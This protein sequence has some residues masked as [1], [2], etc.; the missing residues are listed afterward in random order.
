MVVQINY[1]VTRTRVINAP[2]PS[3]FNLTQLPIVVSTGGTTTPLP[4]ERDRQMSQSVDAQTTT[5]AQVNSSIPAIFRSASPN[6]AT[7]DQTG[8][9]SYVADGECRILADGPNCTLGVLCNVSQVG[10]QTVKNFVD[11]LPGWLS[12]K[13]AHDFDAKLVGTTR[14]INGPALS[15]WSP[16]TR[17]PLCW[18]TQSGVDLTPIMTLNSMSGARD[19]VTLFTPRHVMGCNHNRLSVGTWLQF[20]SQDGTNQICQRT[21]TG[22]LNVTYPLGT[23]SDGQVYVLDSDVDNFIS[24]AMVLPTHTTYSPHLPSIAI[25]PTINPNPGLSSGL[26]MLV[27]DQKKIAN[28]QEWGG[29]ANVPPNEGWTAGTKAPTEGDRAQYAFPPVGGDSG[30]PR[31]LIYN[32]RLVVHSYLSGLTM[33]EMIGQ[34]NAAFNTLGNPNG[35]QLE[36]V[37]FSSFPSWAAPP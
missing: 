1:D 4:D 33:S 24:H 30:S 23:F 15:S 20:L 14:E 11:Y 27:Q 16:L 13:L 28:I 35:Y 3:L 8:R 32:N 12:Y 22:T 37:D 2:P 26:P 17:N 10:G 19:Q 5:E 34:V 7:V 29:D 6:V 21:I 31:C 9:V 36:V 18:A 25:A